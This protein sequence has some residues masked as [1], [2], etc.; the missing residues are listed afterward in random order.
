MRA[1]E[2]ILRGTFVCEFIGEV[3]GVQEADNRRKR[4][5]FLQN[6]LSF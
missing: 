5:P 6:I 2:A 1:G 3:L 4:F